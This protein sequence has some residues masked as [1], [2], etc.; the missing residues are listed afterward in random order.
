MT[1]AAKVGGFLVCLLLSAPV[2]AADAAS[3]HSIDASKSVLTIHVLK[4]GLFSAFGHE[5]RISAPISKGSFSTGQAAAVELT[6]DARKLLVVDK[7]VSDKDR[8]EIQET[9]LGPSVLDSEKFPEIRFQSG[10]VAPAGNGWRISGNLTLHGK[11]A[12]VEVS[13]KESGGHF[14]G[15]AQVKQTDFGITPVTVAGGAVKV[16]D[17]VKIEFDVV[18]Q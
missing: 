7:D 14:L 9:M 10:K 8:A 18:G 1:K 6:V 12:P 2:L 16:K 4:S 11:T 3:S 13:V 17:E 5:H 15:T